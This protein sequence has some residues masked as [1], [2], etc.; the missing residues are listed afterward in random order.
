M[1]N[2]LQASFTTLRRENERLRELLIEALYRSQETGDLTASEIVWRLYASEALGNDSPVKPKPDAL[3]I[4]VHA[5][6]AWRS[7][8]DARGMTISGI[9]DAEHEIRRAISGLD[10]G[11]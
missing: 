11:L 10:E 9:R 3:T 5:V 6:L 2:A 8:K 1:S 7:A 4:L